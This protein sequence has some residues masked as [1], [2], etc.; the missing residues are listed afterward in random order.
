MLWKEKL[1]QLGFTEETAPNMVK[2]AIKELRS[3]E[4]GLE[5]V[6]AKLS[7]GGLSE[8]RVAELEEEAET[9]RSAIEGQDGVICRKI[10]VW[11]KNKEK[12]AEL[13][14]RLSPKKKQSSNE[15]P[16]ITPPSAP[17]VEVIVDTPPVE[18]QNPPANEVVVEKKSKAGTVA[19]FLILGVLSFGAYNYLKNER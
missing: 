3:F 14:K 8:R 7:K 6:N 11:D 5:S 13:G 9:Y 16:E 4:K 10:E 17:P 12:Y 19:L 2:K 1:N 15:P 18:P